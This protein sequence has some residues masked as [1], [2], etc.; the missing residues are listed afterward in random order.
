MAKI[1]VK[2]SADARFDAN[3]EAVETHQSQ[4]RKARYERD[5]DAI[6]AHR[7]QMGKAQYEANRDAIDA[8]RAQV[9]ATRA[10]ARKAIKAQSNG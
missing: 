1:L 7:R 8:H 9:R 6:N 5:K 2:E 4:I 3:R 10:A